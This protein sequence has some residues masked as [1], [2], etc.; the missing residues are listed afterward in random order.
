MDQLAGDAFTMANYCNNVFR[1]LSRSDQRQWAGV[2]VAG[3]LYL[4]LPV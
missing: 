1:S 3:L 2:Y 4:A